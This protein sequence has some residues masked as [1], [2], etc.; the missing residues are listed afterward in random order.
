MKWLVV[1]GILV[2]VACKLR[3][4]L[5]QHQVFG[6]AFRILLGSDSRPMTAR[7]WWKGA[8]LLSTFAAVAFV[9]HFGL[10]RAS[11]QTSWTFLDSPYLVSFGETTLWVGGLALI[12]GAFSLV[13]ALVHAIRPKGVEAKHKEK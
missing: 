2:F 13:A 3:S 5:V 12:G 8:L 11:Q 4:A 9:C 6:P 7:E 1:A 10:I